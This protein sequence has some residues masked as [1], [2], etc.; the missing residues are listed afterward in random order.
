MRILK[1]LDDNYSDTVKV[2]CIMTAWSIDSIPSYHAIS[3]V[4]GDPES[5]TT[6]LIN[7]KPFQVRTNCEFALKQAYWQAKSLYYWVD[8]ICIDQENLDEKSKQ[9]AMMGNIYKRAAHVFACVGNHTDDSLF[10]F[11]NIGPFLLTMCESESWTKSLILNLSRRPGLFKTRR[12][13]RACMDFARRPYFSRLWVLQELKMAKQASLLCGRGVVSKDHFEAIFTRLSLYVYG[14][15]QDPTWKLVSVL[16]RPDAT[17]KVPSSRT[18]DRMSDEKL[19]KTHMANLRL[20]FGTLDLLS[21]GTIPTDL[22]KATFRL[23]CTIP[24]DKVYGII[25][26]LESGGDALIIPDYTKT[27][28]E[29]AVDLLRAIWNTDFIQ[30]QVPGHKLHLLCFHTIVNLELNWEES[31][32]APEAMEARRGPPERAF[33]G[34]EIGSKDSLPRVPSVA[35]G[36]CISVGDLTQ[37]CARFKCWDPP[38]AKKSKVYFP[39]WIKEGDWVV[40]VEEPDRQP[41]RFL[42]L[43]GEVESSRMLIVGLGCCASFGPTNLVETKYEIHW[44]P[45]DVLIFTMLYMKLE[46]DETGSSDWVEALNTGVCRRETPGSS[47]AVKLSNTSEDSGS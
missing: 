32:G 46:F 13:I 1:V 25:S 26:L 7:D 36:F 43:K 10:L 3:Y 41:R 27:E 19:S 15:P 2:R 29:V 37:D 39:Y 4:W 18:V 31:Y 47:Y 22:V 17:Y 11:Q 44:D 23:Q 38:G 8:A 6:I 40:Y 12:L 42:V 35:T 20:V 28:F 24:K 16:L 14:S 21:K 30:E 9:V 45:E 5:N 33:K 34:A